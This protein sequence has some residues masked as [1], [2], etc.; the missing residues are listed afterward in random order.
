M[1]P[2]DAFILTLGDDGALL[3]AADVDAALFVKGHDANA[4]RPILDALR[5]QPRRPVLIL[6]DVLGQEFRHESLPRLGWL[7]QRKLRLRRLQQQFPQALLKTALP[8]RNHTALLAA[9]HEGGVAGWWLERL[10]TLPNPSGGVCLLPLESA[11]MPQRLMPQAATG[12]AVLLGMHRAG[13]L[14]QIV[15]RDGALIFTRLTPPMPPNADGRDIAQ[16]V[17]R[18]LQATRGYLARL[19]LNDDTPLRAA[20]ILPE[21]A[22]AAL[23][24]LSLPVQSLLTLT[25]HQ[26]ARRLALG[27]TPSPLDVSA[28]MLHVGWLTRKRRPRALLMR[29]ETRQTTNSAMLRRWGMRAASAAW[30]LA[31][32]SLA[33]QGQDLLRL[34]LAN[35]RLIADNA[36][37]EEQL[38]QER[39]ARPPVTQPLGRLRLAVERRR[40]YTL[41]Q[42]TPWPLLDKLAETLTTDFRLTK[43]DWNHADG[44]TATEKL[45]IGL[46]LADAPA[47][48]DQGRMA[49]QRFDELAATLRQALPDHA[50]A[51]AQYPFPVMPNDTLS[52]AANAPEAKDCVIAIHRAA[53]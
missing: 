15:T 4:V 51:I 19:G 31:L 20:A 36:A 45:E 7:D 1:R 5:S 24:A 2:A 40:L 44:K 42:E 46:R 14:R 52:N 41:P 10:A 21:H 30:L 25:P 9:L 16:A 29:P 53:P 35:N 48:L 17:A 38:T 49:A 47:S 3:A 8:L 6:A 12:W 22:H 28:D 39:A 23:A 32:G 18:D 33:W 27:L 13:G 37:L 34:G 50:I 11:D 43:L 26:A